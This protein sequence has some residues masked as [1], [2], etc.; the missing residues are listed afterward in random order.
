MRQGSGRRCYT[1]IDILFAAGK[2]FPGGCR[3]QQDGAAFGKT[4]IILVGGGAGRVQYLAG[5]C[6]LGFG[7]CNLCCKKLALIGKPCDCCFGIIKKVCFTRNILCQ[8]GLPVGKLDQCF[9]D[10]R[11][12]AV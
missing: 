3:C 1:V 11:F 7:F 8:L 5:S 9:I 6:L 10:S 2:V 12:F 4:S